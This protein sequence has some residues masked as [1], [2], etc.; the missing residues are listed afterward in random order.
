MTRKEIRVRLLADRALTK[1]ERER[2]P[3][4]SAMFVLALSVT[5]SN[6]R[7]PL[8]HEALAKWSLMLLTGSVATV[9]REM[10]DDELFAS[11]SP[12]NVVLSE[13]E[14]RDA[15][16]ELHGRQ[17]ASAGRHIALTG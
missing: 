6:V 4:D 5:R 13:Q 9:R 2:I 14:R 1:I 11:L 8:M 16:T 17:R 7:G 3:L 10:D 15:L 12:L